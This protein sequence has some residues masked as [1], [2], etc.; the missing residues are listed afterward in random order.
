MQTSGEDALT[1]WGEL[2]QE[3]KKLATLVGPPRPILSPKKTG[4]LDKVKFWGKAS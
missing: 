1:N 2:A 4:M 3:A